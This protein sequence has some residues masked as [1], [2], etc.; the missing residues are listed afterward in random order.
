MNKKSEIRVA[1][2][3]VGNCASSLVQG[4]EFYKEAQGNDYVPGLM[5]T[6]I[7]PYKIRDIKVVAA[8]D[9]DVR[10]V[11][12]DVSEAIFS[13]P[14]CT[15]KFSSDIP[16]LNAPVYMG[17]IL[18]GVSELM[19][20]GKDEGYPIFI[21]SNNDSVIV[22]EKLRE[23]KVDVLVN[24]LPVG[25]RQATA[26]YAQAAIDA[27]CSFVNAMP[28]FIASDPEWSKKFEEAGLPVIGD[29][30][31][32]QFGAT[33]S[34]RI[35]IQALIDRG[36]KV[37][38]TEQYN[39]GG[40]TDFRNMMDRERLKDKLA[41]KTDSIEKRIPYKLEQSLYAGPGTSPEGEG[42]KGHGF[43][44][45]QGDNKI[46]EI[47]FN[48][49][50]FG[51]VPITGHLKIDCFDSPNSGGIVIDAI[52]CAQLARDMGLKGTINSASA[53][54]F[55]HPL[56]DISDAQALQELEAFIASYKEFSATAEIENDVTPSVE[57]EKTILQPTEISNF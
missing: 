2:V 44:K 11:G 43:V 6:E 37:L 17:S 32:S 23:H 24:Y 29:D 27:K 19:K 13:E 45:G 4:I 34:H 12:K 47:K 20:T 14:N 53:W 48:A 42:D 7:G 21:P 40:N 18:D 39:Y 15:L 22:T 5:H 1:I 16:Y 35:L 46:A 8:F 25:S 54:F 9:V 31:K 3:G 41:S 26:F 51:G 55:K 50:G 56:V 57:E 49:T 38:T 52:R 36:V 30:I 10:K 33:F 28:R